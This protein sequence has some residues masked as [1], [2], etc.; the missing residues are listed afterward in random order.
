M[1]V[2]T[3]SVS[4]CTPGVVGANSS[5]TGAEQ[6]AASSAEASS[7]GTTKARP[8]STSAPSRLSV[9]PP[10][11]RMPTVVSARS[12]TAVAPNTT[13]SW[14][15]PISGRVARVSVQGPDP[16]PPGRQP[17]STSR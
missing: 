17:P 9:P 7:G 13:S 8:R 10:E 4:V 5:V 1:S 2:V 12:P 15:E 16:G 3:T 6:P 14:A 11:L